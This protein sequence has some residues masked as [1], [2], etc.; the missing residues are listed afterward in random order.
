[1]SANLGC[2]NKHEDSN[3]KPAYEVDVLIPEVIQARYFTTSYIVLARLHSDV[4]G[5]IV[6]IFYFKISPLQ[7]LVYYMYSHYIKV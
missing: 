4:Q 7:N 5:L 6:M 3:K 2:K 1:M